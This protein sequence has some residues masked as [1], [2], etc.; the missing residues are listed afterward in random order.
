[1]LTML[2]GQSYIDRAFKA[3]AMDYVLVVATTAKV[4]ADLKIWR[5]FRSRRT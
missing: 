4:M 1:M 2:A 3:G 5:S